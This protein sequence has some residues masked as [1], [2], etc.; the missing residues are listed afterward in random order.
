MTKI[1]LG[2]ILLAEAASSANYKIQSDSLNFGGVLSTSTNYRLE[3]TL[4]ESATGLIS[5]ANY[6]IDAGYQAMVYSSLSI[7]AP[8]DLTLSSIVSTTG[9]LSSGSVVW[10]VTTDNAAGYT[11][12]IKAGTS[13]ALKSSGDSFADYT[14]A[15][16]NPDYDWSVATNA[17]EFGFSP[18]G[19]DVASRYLDNGSA[20][21]VG[22]GETADRCWDAFSTTN[23]TIA[24]R[25]SANTPG[26]IVTTVKLQAEVKAGLA[27]NTGAYS[28]T[29]TATALAS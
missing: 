21:S 9:G 26:G 4:G 1:F 24:S 18:E 5:S 25:A 14:L 15:D 2:L 19:A 22:A 23:R 10:T 29:L 6:K 8:T 13:P 27:Q 17:A 28:A 7:S 3:D 20:C 11:L 16:A 12:A